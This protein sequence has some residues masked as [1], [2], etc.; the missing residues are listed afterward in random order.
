MKTYYLALFILLLACNSPEEE[1]RGIFKSTEE[2]SDTIW[3]VAIKEVQYVQQD[4]GATYESFDKET[5]GEYDFSRVPGEC[6]LF[7][8]ELED[9]EIIFHSETLVQV[10]VS[11]RLETSLSISAEGPHC[12]LIH[13]K[14]GAT[15]WKKMEPDKASNLEELT[16]TRFKFEDKPYKLYASLPFPV[17]DM[18]EI[19][20]AVRKSCGS[21][22]ADH[23]STCKTP[24]DYPCN[25]SISNYIFRV[26]Y[27]SETTGET[28]YQYLKIPVPMGC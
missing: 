27:E 2:S 15:P 26:S 1:N 17:S 13:W 24:Y 25:V 23:M 8:I 9:D 16:Y 18:N 10:S 3:D 20:S 14:H 5:E 19:K 11:Y 12:D 28:V 6:G 22:W 4:T 7:S 21:D